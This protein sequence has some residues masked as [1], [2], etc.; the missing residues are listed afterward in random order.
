MENERPNVQGGSTHFAD[1]GQ[2][3]TLNLPPE[4]AANPASG[5]GLH[6]DLFPVRGQILQQSTHQAQLHDRLAQHPMSPRVQPN[7]PFSQGMYE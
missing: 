4:H 3:P 6:P 5:E 1:E 2:Q 7:Q